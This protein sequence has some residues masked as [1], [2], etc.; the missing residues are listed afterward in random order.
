MG[1]S[2][3]KV[4]Q[5]GVVDP[6]K[7]GAKGDFSTAISHGMDPLGLSGGSFFGDKVTPESPEAA[8]L[9]Q[10]KLEAA[11][12]ERDVLGKFRERMDEDVAG[13]IKGDI[14]R[15]DVAAAAAEEDAMRQARDRVRQQG[16]QRSSIGQNVQANIQRESARQRALNR[17]TGTRRA[18]QEKERRLTTF[19]NVAAGTLAN[20]N[21]PIRFEPVKEESFF[22]QLLRS[23]VQAG[24]QGGAQALGRSFGAA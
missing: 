2:L 23:G 20:Q 16:L 13:L 8:E 4:I 24:A 18:D 12:G 21:V 9:R 22:K 17:A 6:I 3:K 11:R 1:F 14:E 10:I 7:Y 19:R 15:E 5:R